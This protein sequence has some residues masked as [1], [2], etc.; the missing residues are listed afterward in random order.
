MSTRPGLAH[1]REELAGLLAPAR[2]AGSRVG[3]ACP[4]WAPCTRATP[5]WCARPASASADRPRRGR[6]SSSTRCSSRRARTSTAIPRTLEADLELCAAEGVDVVFAP[7]RRGGLPAAASPQV[8]VDP[9]PLAAVLEGRTR[10][11]HFRG[12]LTVVAKLFG[13]VR[14]DVA[15]FGQKD[16]QQLALIRRMV[17]RPHAAA[18]R[19]SAPRPCASPTASR[20]P[21]ATATSTPSSAARRPRSAARCA[22]P[23]SRRAYGATTVAL[24]AGP[25]RAAPRQ[26]R[27]PRLPR[28]HRARPG[29]AARRGAR[30][31]RGPASSI[32]ARVG[33]HPA[34]R[35]PAHHPRASRA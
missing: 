29:A 2:A 17:A 16:Y 1:T 27:R 35:Q 25:R 5:A 15:V 4:R 22:P 28:A 31:H 20:C 18:S 33:Q 26:G 11:G 19:S 24:D 3:A 23:R 14:P 12:V 8:T 10:P 13:L 30:G 32:A 34:D 6:R 7:S 9:G 21:A